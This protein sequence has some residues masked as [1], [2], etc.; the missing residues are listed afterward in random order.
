MIISKDEY[1][2]V[3]FRAP[4]TASVS[5]NTVL[6]ENKYVRRTYA[7]HYTAKKYKKTNYNE[8]NKRLKFGFARNPYDRATSYYLYTLQ[9]YNRRVRMGCT[10]RRKD[11]PC[12]FQEFII[13]H[14]EMLSN[15]TCTKYLF[16]DDNKILV[17]YIGRFENLQKDFNVMCKKIG[18]PLMKIPHEN[19]S[20]NKKYY[21]EYYCPKTYDLVTETYKDD[22]KNFNYRW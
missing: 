22:L 4:K 9:I 13:G 3:I 16:D 15:Q 6:K 7:M 1:N 5:I 17:D 12:S 2:F 18:I 10:N 20:Q 14:R 19:K 8:F 21:K 11:T